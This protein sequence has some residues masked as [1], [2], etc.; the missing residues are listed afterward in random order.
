MQ[1]SSL[2]VHLNLNTYKMSTCI[3]TFCDGQTAIDK[4]KYC[5]QLSAIVCPS[6][7]LA[8]VCTNIEI[9]IKFTTVS[10]Q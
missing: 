6:T 8:N 5:I 2:A 9:S 3:I 1:A 10:I 7:S 4:I